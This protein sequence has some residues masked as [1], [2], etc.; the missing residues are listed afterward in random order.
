MK[1]KTEKIEGAK[2]CP[3][4]L[5]EAMVKG[6]AIKCLDL[7]GEPVDIVGWTGYSYIDSEGCDFNVD[8]VKP[9]TAWEPQ[10]GEV[11]LAWDK[12]DT[13]AFPMIFDSIEDNKIWGML[14]CT[15]DEGC[16]VGL[17][18]AHSITPFSIELFTKPI[19]EWPKDIEIIHVENIKE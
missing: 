13:A 12:Q 18:S 1:Y 9:I 7:D 16:G 6:E 2:A 17:S 4:W 3:E 8:D 14:Q 5:A 19:S 10:E 11:V 15:D